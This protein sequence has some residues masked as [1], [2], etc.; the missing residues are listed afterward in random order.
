[1]RTEAERGAGL[2]VAALHVAGLWAVA[3]AQPLYDVVSRSPEFFVAH[4]A[5]PLDVVALILTLGLIGPAA[6]ILAIAAADRLGARWRAVTLGVVVGALCGTIAL[7]A[8]RAWGDWSGPPTLGVAAAVA[9]AAGYAYVR[10]APV[11]LFATFLSPAALVVPV[12]FLLNP[13][14]AP[15]LSPPETERDAIAGATFET[16]PPVVVVVFDQLPLASLLDRDGAI[17]RTLYPHFAALADEAT[18]FRNA[19]AVSPITSSA[20]PAILTGRYPVRGLLPTVDDHPEN[21]FTLLGS[22]YRLEVIEPLTSLC[23][24][25][26]CPV[27]RPGVVAWLGAVLRDL[28]IVWLQ[29]VLPEDLTRSLPPVTQSWADF[30]ALEAPT[31]QDVWREQRRDDRRRSVEQFVARLGA[32]GGNRP[33]LHFLHVLLP[34]EP[35]VYLPTGQRFSFRPHVPG[36]S[37]NSNWIDD[38]RPVA[39]NY[40][41]HLLQV[42]YVD[43]I[44]GDIVVR[45]RDAGTWDDALVVVVADHGASFRPGHPLRRPRDYSFSDVASVPLLVKL[46]GQRTGSVNRANVEIVDILPTVAAV[47]GAALPWEVDG[48][49]ALGARP[50]ARTAKTMFLFDA[51]RQMEGPADLSDQLAEMVAR[52]FAIFENGSPFDSPATSKGYERLVGEP[53]AAYASGQPA[54]F[55]ATLDAVSLLSEVRPDGDFVPAQITGAVIPREVP[56]PTA[57]LAVAINGTVAAVTQPYT[58][59]VSGRTGMWEALVAPRWLGAGANT[60]AVFAIREDD[61]GTIV[62]DEAYRFDGAAAPAPNNLIVE[63]VAASRG[64]TLSGFYLQEWAGMRAFRWTDGHGRLEVPIDPRSPPA[65]LGIEVAMTGGRPA[66]KVL[67]IDVNGCTVHRGIVTGGSSAVYPFDR[68]RVGGE[69]A[70][71]DFVSGSHV[72]RMDDTRTLGVAFAVVELL[73]ADPPEIAP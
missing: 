9:G 26:L 62:L 68:C 57:S 60:V 28:R 16:T 58:F 24:T 66:R 3:V 61:A 8:I 5:R 11:R 7:A 42:G 20:L 41:R 51:E 1:M 29:T 2:P 27:E 4:D 59:S 72:P 19:S 13:A 30:A 23:P 12:V 48:A 70:V 71:I 32:G 21:L 39:R 25:S 69:M 6:C 49:D 10:T 54:P 44:L 55:D 33:V 37:S 17:D 67:R 22:R 52:K 36:L 35:W 64:A 15:L 63:E 45:L 18:W 47:L 14:I 65:A 46:P 40:Q 31:F 34:H 43:T 38:P 50:A 56:A 53:A 73:E